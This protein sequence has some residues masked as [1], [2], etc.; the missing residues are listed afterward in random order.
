MCKANF[1]WQENSYN[2]IE[3]W[4]EAAKEVK[5]IKVCTSYYNYIVQTALI[6]Q[7]DKVMH[8][9]TRPRA[10]NTKDSQAHYGP[11]C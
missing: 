7:A 9:L 10:V 8:D 3:S 2:L 1:E 4:T 6:H 5:V 11:K